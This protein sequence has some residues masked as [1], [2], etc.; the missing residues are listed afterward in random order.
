MFEYN[1][2]DRETAIYTAKRLVID[3]I[4]KIAN[5]EIRKGIT[6]PETVE[7][8]EG[9]VPAGS[10][11]EKV[12]VVNNLKH[13]W[14]FLLDNVDY[15]LDFQLVSEYNRLVGAGMEKDPGK[16]RIVQIKSS[17]LTLTQ[18]QVV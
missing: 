15:P 14:Q 18:G 10:D 1:E 9:R 12:V 2:T 11:V 17:D 4:W 16:L 5:I 3:S 13:A 7:I 8:F 6:F